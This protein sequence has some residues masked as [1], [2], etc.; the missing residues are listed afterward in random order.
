MVQG[1]NMRR[2]SKLNH[3]GVVPNMNWTGAACQDIN[4]L[5]QVHQI[6]LKPA[7]IVD[8]LVCWE[9]LVAACFT[10][11]GLVHVLS[12]D[13]RRQK[14]SYSFINADPSFLS[15]A[16]DMDGRDHYLK[17]GLEEPRT[18][19]SVEFGRDGDGSPVLY[20]IGLNHGVKVCE[21]DC[22]ALVKYMELQPKQIPVYN[23][24]EG[25]DTGLQRT[26]L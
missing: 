14:Q 22:L 19:W 9:L 25:V 23:M 6:K 4:S 16:H 1:V 11:V 13:T 12:H 18:K 21:V 15:V 7:F 10:L 3:E 2:Q 24:G 20:I 5:E 8:Q 17:I 26:T